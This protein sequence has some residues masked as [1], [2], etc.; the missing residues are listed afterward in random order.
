MHRL[1]DDR[2][3]ERGTALPRRAEAA[4]KGALDRKVQVRVWHDDERVL[5]SELQARRLQVAPAELSYLLAH[6]R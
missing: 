4:E 3:A 5:T 6:L 2:R 1:V